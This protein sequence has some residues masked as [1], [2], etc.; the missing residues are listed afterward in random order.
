MNPQASIDEVGPWKSSSRWIGSGFVGEV[1]IVTPSLRS[2]VLV[3]DPENS[4]ES[5]GRDPASLTRRARVGRP[6]NELDTL[7]SFVTDAVAAGEG[8]DAGVQT[9]VEA[10]APLTTL[11]LPR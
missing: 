5:C 1:M 6:L 3:C 8:F 10:R 7:L 4:V 9:A 11:P 2:S